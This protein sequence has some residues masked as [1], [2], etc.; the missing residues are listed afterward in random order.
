M[1]LAV[2]PLLAVVF[3]ALGTV[4]LFSVAVLCIPTVPI[5]AVA[6]LVTLLA[7]R[8]EPHGS[9]DLPARPRDVAYGH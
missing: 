5:V 8:A 6:A 1:V 4:F 7:S 9:P 2:A 3:A